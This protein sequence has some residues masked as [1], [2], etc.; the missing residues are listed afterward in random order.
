MLNQPILRRLHRQE[1]PQPGPPEGGS[2][3]SEV[4][5]RTRSKQRACPRSKQVGQGLGQRREGCIIPHTGIPWTVR[6]QGEGSSVYKVFALALAVSMI[7]RHLKACLCLLPRGQD[8]V[9][10]SRIR[11]FFT[12]ALD[13]SQYSWPSPRNERG[14]A[15]IIKQA[16]SQVANFME[17]M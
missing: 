9:P 8:G 13:D 10:I 1:V 16:C 11:S 7:C 5:R 14:T 2:G 6:V 12:F 3:A 4:A 15:Q 17:R